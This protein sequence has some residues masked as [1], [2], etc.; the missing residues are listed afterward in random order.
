MRV[1]NAG[2]AAAG[3]PPRPSAAP[4]ERTPVALAS[5]LKQ[6]IRR[7]RGAR[8]RQG[9]LAFYERQNE[10][11]DSLLEADQLHRGVGRGGCRAAS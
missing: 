8:G 2:A 7:G 1:Q 4:L 3:A 6:G 10:L 9:L 5:P 11:I